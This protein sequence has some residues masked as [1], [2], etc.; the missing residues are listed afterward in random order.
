M[1]W[2]KSSRDEIRQYY[3]EEFPGRRDEIPEF[4]SADG[5]K[6]YAIAF[7]ASHPIKKDEAPAREFIRR[8][9]RNEYDSGP[10]GKNFGSFDHVLN[11]IQRPARCDPFENSDYALV[12][13]DLLDKPD[14]LPA[15]VYYALDHWERS[16][17]I[18]VDIDAKDIALER[19]RSLINGGSK[20]SDDEVRSE[21][22]ILDA[23]PEGYPYAFEDI[24]QALEYGFTVRDLFEDDFAAEETMVVYSGQGCHVY[25]LDDDR[26]HHYDTKSREVL[27]D[28][29]TNRRGIPIDTVVTAD[30]QR[31]ARLPYTLHTDVS[32][33]V[34]PIDSPTFNFREEAN[35]AFLSDR[36]ERSLEV[37]Q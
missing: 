31:V 28:Y 23:A 7:R 9:T 15:G 19:G 17:I 24:K 26:N 5:P 13:P 30:R 33:V 32:R 20:L 37:T 34:Q 1:T 16:W 36:P 12:N 3:T 6:E 10:R 8:G 35:P 22:G 25:L 2:R 27:V 14:P 29:L 21:A 4:I 11:F 18:L